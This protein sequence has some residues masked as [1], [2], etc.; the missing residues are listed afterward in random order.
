MAGLRAAGVGG[1]RHFGGGRSGWSLLAA[2]RT[3]ARGGVDPT[4]NRR[5]Q[6]SGDTE[7]FSGFS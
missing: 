3:V 5:M 6:D 1:W 2:Y 7:L 4:I